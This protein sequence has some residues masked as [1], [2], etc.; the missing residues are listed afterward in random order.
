MWN[1]LRPLF[2]LNYWFSAYTLPFTPV[3]SWV[4]L[5]LMAVLFLAGLYVYVAKRRSE[6]NK[7]MKLAWR[8]L[9]T[10]F[11][12][13]S[14]TGFILWFFAWQLIPYLG[15]R[16]LWIVW[17]IAYGIWGY[18]IWRYVKRELPAKQAKLAEKA[19]NDKWLPKPKK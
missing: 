15:A 12:W 8:R 2:S 19:A 16:A 17:L 9:G 10:L 11:M 7:D 5:G 6:A 4:I 14:I 1:F 3:L 18:Q 13:A